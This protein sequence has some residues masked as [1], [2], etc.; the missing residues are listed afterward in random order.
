MKL[1]RLHRRTEALM[2]L[3]AVIAFIS[4]AG[5]DAPSVLPALVLLIAVTVWEPSSQLRRRLEPLFKTIAIILAGRAA[6]H[7]IRS[8]EDIVLPMVDLLLRLLVA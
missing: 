6:Y 3:T 8:P 1:L 2:T 7:V 4:G 5:F